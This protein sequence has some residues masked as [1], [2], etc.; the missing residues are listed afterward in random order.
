M[1]EQHFHPL[2]AALS[3]ALSLGI[4]AH[5][6]TQESGVETI[7]VT[8]RALQ[9]EIDLTAGAVPTLHRRRRAA[10]NATRRASPTCS[11]TCPASGP[12]SSQGSDAMSFSSR[13]SN[14]DATD[15]DS[16]GIEVVQDGL[17]VTTADGNNHNRVVDPLSVRTRHRARRECAQ[18]RREH[19]R[20][21]DRL[22]VADRACGRR[23]VR[24]LRQQLSRRLVFTSRLAGGLGQLEIEAAQEHLVRFARTAVLRDDEARA[25]LEDLA[26][27]QGKKWHKP[28]WVLVPR[29]W[30]CTISMSVRHAK[31]RWR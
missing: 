3:T 7:V 12:K 31:A 18:L 26:S 30:C 6:W 11:A 14:L 9:S 10:S 29:G 27:S 5:A 13:G 17:P 8:D 22:P 1:R 21:R 16:N 25:R 15:Y 4:S 24:R 19:P 20:R 23:S 2:I 28:D